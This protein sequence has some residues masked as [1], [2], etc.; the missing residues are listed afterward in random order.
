MAESVTTAY[1]ITADLIRAFPE[2]QKVYD[3]YKA[4]DTTQAELEYYKTNY[5]R[6]LT[7]TS[8][9][10]AQ[11]KAS[12][13]G[14]YNQGLETFKLEQR[15]RLITK[16]IN[17]DEA[18]FNS[19]IQSAYD[20]GLDDNQ[21]DLQALSKF[22]GTVGGETLGR[23]QTLEEYAKSF[24]MSYSPTTLNSWSQGLVSGTNTIFDIQE[25]IRRDSASA[26]PVF[27]DDINKGTSVDALASAY[28]N[29]MATI[30]EI[31]ADTISYNDPTFR[32][33]LQYIGPD[34]KPAV[35]P[36]WQFEAELRQDPR[37]DLTDNARATV[38]SLSLK[39]L[40]DYG[41]A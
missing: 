24:G 10:R 36:I 41:V 27:A 1:G 17:L 13:P 3:L 28:K 12:Q 31:D 14:V 2:L 22:K 15:R 18:T 33:A 35:K 20:K 29:S 26:Y 23:V 32:R 40:R 30:L 6:N 34:G 21:I 37:W 5:Y 7:T 9:N 19:I 25:K 16:G 39:V 38:D 4:G 11:Q 8:K